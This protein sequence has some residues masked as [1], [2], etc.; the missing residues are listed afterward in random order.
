MSGREIEL[1][2]Q[3]RLDAERM[4]QHLSVECNLCGAWSFTGTLREYLAARNDHW[5]SEHPHLLKRK[6]KT[7]RVAFG[8][9]VTEK[10]LD[11]NIAGV[12]GQGGH[13]FGD[14]DEAA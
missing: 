5:A 8:V 9:V 10:T 6:T 3:Q 1:A 14:L 4:E 12:R 2:Y 11:E 13:R 7:K